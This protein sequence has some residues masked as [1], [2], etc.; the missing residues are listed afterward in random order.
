MASN[1]PL[2][3]QQKCGSCG[4]KNDKMAIICTNCEQFLPSE[5]EE[6]QVNTWLCDICQFNNY[7]KLY[8]LQD[9]WTLKIL[10]FSSF[11]EFD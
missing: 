6:A 11:A 5:A 10:N 9:D 3:T 4:H 2:L 1:F 8:I 7:G